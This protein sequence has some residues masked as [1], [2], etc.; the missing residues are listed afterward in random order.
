V[1]AIVSPH[2]APPPPTALW[3]TYIWVEDADRAVADVVAAGG[4]VIGQP[5]DSP[6]DGRMA[7]LG[8]PSGA[9][10]G[11]WQPRSHR[12]A[13]IVN[14]PG[15]WAMSML[16]TPD[17]ERATAF[18][19]TVF[20]WETMSFGPATLYRLPGYV[21][22]EPHQPVPRDVIAAMVPLNGSDVP[23]HWAHDF[24]VSDADAI[25]EQATALGGTVV[26]PVHEDGG[27]RRAVIVDPQGA[28]VSISQLIVN[29]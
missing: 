16:M 23:P 4:H 9:V 17:T 20:G 28:T 2:G 18:Y 10:F 11:V 6:G 5:F 29:M 12:G 26:V 15:A 25:A 21:G 19:G 1:A 27:F 14:E 22:G 3:G 7:V 13:E 8:D 24:W